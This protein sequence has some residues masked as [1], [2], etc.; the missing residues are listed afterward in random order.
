MTEQVYGQNG[1]LSVRR[2]TWLTNI[3]PTSLRARLAAFREL[4]IYVPYLGLSRAER[5]KPAVL[6]STWVLGGYVAGKTVT[7]IR[8]DAAMTKG[9]FSDL[10]HSFSAFAGDPGSFRLATDRE[11]EEWLDLLNELSSADLKELFPAVE[12]GVGAG[13]EDDLSFELKREFGMPPVKVQA[14]REFLRELEEHLSQQRAEK[15][16]VYWAVASHEPAGKPLDCCA[17]VPVEL[18]LVDEGD[19][20]DRAQDADF[21]RV[22]EM[23]LKKAGR[24]AT[25]AKRAGGYLTY[26]D[27]GFLLGIH[28]AAISALLQEN[29][30]SVLPLRGSECDIGRGLT[31]RRKIVQLFLEMYTE[32]EIADRTGHSYEAIENY[33]KEFGTVMLLSEQGLSVPMIRKVTGRSTGLVRAYL[34]LLAE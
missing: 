15:K 1:L 30:G 7:E 27:L 16:V 2:L 9:H 3:T 13:Q 12:S 25:E 23:K 31:H 10:L 22:K 24:Y 29:A 17:L 28:P 33:I 18:T 11:R 20:P 19:I 4:G 32:T 5:K 14:T 8:E 21:N 26:A 34:D 6:R